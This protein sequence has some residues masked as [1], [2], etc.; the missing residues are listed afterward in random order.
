MGL[1][2]A[3]KAFSESSLSPGGEEYRKI[4]IEA[5][6]KIAADHLCAPREVELAALNNNVVPE[7][8]Q[9]SLGTVGGVRGQLRL[10]QCCVGIV[11]LG[12]LGGLAADMLARMGIGL[13]VL[14]DGDNFAESNLNRQNISCEINIGQNKA[15]AARERIQQVNSSVEVTQFE[16]FV[17]ESTILEMLKGCHLVL[18]CLDNLPTRFLLQKSCRKLNIPLVHGAIAQFYGQVS[19]IF[20]G[21]KGLEA[22]YGPVES[23]QS[24]G[25][26]KELGNPATTAS[27]VSS[28]QVQEALKVLLD[29]GSL[30]RNNFLF[31]DTL[32]NSWE[33][34]NCE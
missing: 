10:L 31:I 15:A 14:I 11:G 12:G 6:K 2:E 34:I 9:R 8:Y 26:E 33:I 1:N 16:Q 22:I 25:V 32:E 27:L 30:Y 23:G 4:S 21:D 13:L 3:V 19:T 20:P 24:K 29:K 7:R 17:D 18:D 28:L 5:V